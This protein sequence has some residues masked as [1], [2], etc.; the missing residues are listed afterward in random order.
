MIIMIMMM[1]D[2][3]DGSDDDNYG[4]DNEKWIWKLLDK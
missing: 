1:N 2:D 4:V 3:H